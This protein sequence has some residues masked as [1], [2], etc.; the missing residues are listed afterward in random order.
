MVPF[1]NCSPVVEGV[2]KMALIG[3]AVLLM[4]EPSAA[5]AATKAAKATATQGAA[6]ELIADSK[7]KPIKA[8][9]PAEKTVYGAQKKYAPPTT[10]KKSAPTKKSAPVKKSAP[11]K[12]KTFKAAS[13]AP[14][15]FSARKAGEAQG[16]APAGVTLPTPK[17]AVVSSKK[18]AVRKPVTANKSISENPLAKKKAV[19]AAG[20]AATAVVVEQAAPVVEAPP[21]P[22]VPKVKNYVKNTPA[23]KAAS[24]PKKATS[25]SAP[26]FSLGGDATEAGAVAVAEIVGV[27]VA[28][29][30]VGGLLSGPRAR[31]T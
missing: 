8:K 24:A 25:S 12:Q 15:K 21:A 3:A 22:V 30:I 29:S 7:V 13:T 27:V 19:A 26:S 2:K 16:K 20:A 9:A 11:A 23:V 17:G 14:V 18:A 1:P 5:L 31:R 28:N 4:S 10:A 6:F